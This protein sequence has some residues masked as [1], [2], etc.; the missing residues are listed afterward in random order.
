MKTMALYDIHS[1]FFNELNDT[2]DNDGDFILFKNIIIKNAIFFGNFKD[3]WGSSKYF[4]NKFK[5]YKNI[6]MN[7]IIF[8]ILIPLA[9]LAK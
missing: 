1:K 6:I 7:P 2:N 9:I 4:Q 8:V 3:D 5:Y